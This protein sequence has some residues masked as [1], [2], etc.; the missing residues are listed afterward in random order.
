M[1][2]LP[3]SEEDYAYKS[4]IKDIYIE[5]PE[6]K[7]HHGSSE[8]NDDDEEDESVDDF[9]I[10]RE[11]ISK[12]F[13]KVLAD[14]N[15]T[16]AYLVT[17]YRGMGKTTF[18]KKVLNEYKKVQE[19][20]N[21]YLGP[22]KTK[23]VLQIDISFAQSDLKDIDILK[24]ITK[25]LLNHVEN[26]LLIKYIYKLFS[27]WTVTLYLFPIMFFF[28]YYLSLN[29][30]RGG[31]LSDFFGPGFTKISV[32]ADGTNLLGLIGLALFGSLFIYLIIIRL[33]L[34]KIPEFFLRFIAIRP[35]D[36]FLRRFRRKASSMRRVH[37][38]IFL[39]PVLLLVTIAFN[40]LLNSQSHTAPLFDFALKISFQTVIAFIIVFLIDQIITVQFDRLVEIY[41]R[42]SHLNDRCSTTMVN[43][44]GLQ[45][46][47]INLPIGFIEKKTRN[48]PIANAKEIEI[49]LT[50]IL[51]QLSSLK[52]RINRYQFVFVF[53]EL[54]KVESSNW[55]GVYHEDF[56]DFEKNS[57]ERIKANE[58]RDRKEVIM[59]ILASLKFFVNEA[60]AKFVFIA[61]R[62]MFEASL[63]DI[64]DRQSA[65][66]SIFHHIIYVDSFLKDKF[67]TKD[68]STL[69]SEMVEHYVLKTFYKREEYEENSLTLKEYYKYLIETGNDK[70]EKSYTDKKLIRKWNVVKKI[71]EIVKKIAELDKK[72]KTDKIEKL[73][74]SGI[75]RLEKEEKTL[76][77]KVNELHNKKKEELYKNEFE[78][79]K[80]IFTLQNFIVY[81]TYRSNGSPK[82]LLKLLESHFAVR[83]NEDIKAR[84]N[85]NIIIENL[86]STKQGNLFLHF[87]YQTQYKLGFITYLYRPFIFT[88]G[89]YLKTYSDSLLVST[90]FLMDHLIKYHKFAFSLHHLE[91]I[92]EIISTNKHTEMRF[93]IQ[94]LVNYLGNTHIRDTEIG[95][96]DYKFYNKTYLE[97]NYLSKT[98]EEE[99]AAFNFTLDENYGVKMY[100]RIKIKE[101]RSIYKDYKEKENF[102]HSIA[103]LNIQLGDAQ[104]F[105]TEYEDAITSYSDAIHALRFMKKN[106]LTFKQFIFLVNCKLKLGLLYEKMKF[107]DM[108]LGYYSD[109][110]EEFKNYFDTFFQKKEK[111]KVEI[112]DE[113][114]QGNDTSLAEADSEENFM[115]KKEYLLD[116][117]FDSIFQIINQAYLASLYVTEKFSIEGV[118]VNKIEKSLENFIKDIYTCNSRKKL[119]EVVENKT[120][121]IKTVQTKLEDQT[122]FEIQSHINPKN[123]IILANFYSNTGTLLFYKNYIKN[124]FDKEEKKTENKPDKTEQVIDTNTDKKEEIIENE[125]KKVEEAAT[126]A[127][128]TATVAEETATV[129]EQTAT[130]AEETATVV[131]Q[132]ATIAE[133]TAT[134]AEQ[135]ATVAEET[136]TIKEEEAKEDNRRFPELPADY[137][138]CALRELV[139][140][141]GAIINYNEKAIVDELSE[142]IRNY[143][144][145]H[146]KVYLKNVAHNL[147]KLADS[148]LVSVEVGEGNM[149][150]I[151]IN[152]IFTSKILNI[153]GDI[154]AHKIDNVFLNGECKE[155]TFRYIFKLY[156]L[157][158]KYYLKAGRNQ[159][160]SF[161]L[162]KILTLLNQYCD[163]TNEPKCEKYISIIE[164]T[165]FKEIMLIV[166][167]NGYSSDRNQIQKYKKAFEINVPYNP[168]GYSKYIYNH[169]SNNPETMEAILL[170][171]NLK[172]KTSTLDKD[173]IHESAENFILHPY[174]AISSQ[175]SHLL[176]LEFQTDFNKKLMESFGGLKDYLDVYQK[177]VHKHLYRPPHD[178]E[179]NENREIRQRGFD[180]I[181]N[182]TVR[183]ARLY[184]EICINSI[185]CLRE[186][187]SIVNIYG[188]NYMLNYTRLGY[189]HEKLGDWIVLLDLFKYSA[190]QKEFHWFTCYLNENS[191]LLQEAIK[192]TEE[193][194]KGIEQI[195]NNSSFNDTLNK[196]RELLE[197][198]NNKKTTLEQTQGE[199][200]SL[201]DHFNTN[202]ENFESKEEEKEID[203]INDAIRNADNELYFLFEAYKKQEETIDFKVLDGEES[204]K[205]LTNTFTTLSQKWA[206]I[207][208]KN[209]E[210][211]E[212]EIGTLIKILE[213]KRYNPVKTNQF[214]KEYKTLKKYNST[215]LKKLKL[216][217][218]RNELI[219][220]LSR[221]TFR[222]LI[223][224]TNFDTLDP[225]T[226]YQMALHLYQK[227]NLLHSEGGVYKEHFVDM[228]Y[229]E[230][231]FSDNLYHFHIALDRLE[232]N[233]GEIEKRIQ[234]L[235]SAISESLIYKYDYY[236]N[237]E[238]F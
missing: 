113:T 54:D 34:F 231:D 95:L 112:K 46:A 108:A 204:L 201:I 73:I 205:N 49:E 59:G 192:N 72:E 157:S 181:T 215:E 55:K 22:N 159:S 131:E 90:P 36:F 208:I 80:V 96:F 118:T 29:P 225:L 123:R 81:L 107:Y 216:T 195:T 84:L 155:H 28:I 7:F 99:A 161:Q 85:K 200:K 221:I 232:I 175:L 102:I 162:R 189:L 223:G 178:D 83:S 203:K 210:T 186:A 158:G 52:H 48:Y 233:S 21:S 11:E 145:K 74:K 220:N 58:F 188:I 132:T 140:A 226:E 151:K 224:P 219:Y 9:F 38:Y 213:S 117:S 199:L 137:Y 172:L 173:S 32:F 177:Q 45:S 10:G 127:K 160:Y 176:Q 69:L 53:D 120:L 198:F 94:D 43:E 20:R 235:N 91:L 15:E 89:Q 106:Q 25:S 133:Q 88:Y 184:M 18:V 44:S 77:N 57:Q 82:K 237:S 115:V 33:I 37:L 61:G 238:K 16:G 30:D 141:Q 41:Q 182:L 153:E 212:K 169:I 150:P 191:E 76:E 134:I 67:S 209:L 152:E 190:R 217:A 78:A 111:K 51:K 202:K 130:V 92:P 8:R 197:I 174:S 71:K 98:N 65:I 165:L 40:I 109:V 31:F 42:L 104:Y 50:N 124:T 12:Y 75:E 119:E 86:A 230:D 14:G 236:V 56:K 218:L 23:R 164:K 2:S 47:G 116:T 171:A 121:D 154:D 63:A 170:L 156:Y 103:F 179:S 193:I 105:D 222:D 1:S 138:K 168:K 64:S 6:Y 114:N 100:L 163:I 142:K 207:P 185:F 194:I 19:E 79:Q 24:L 148:L 136:T 147:S 39:T 139:L 27:D 101:M 135:T 126:V 229:L 87:S 129:A 234:K 144:N 166:S 227:T 68:K 122:N 149:K 13:T 146:D 17:G 66:G 4:F 187:I 167:L 35:I 5:L 128:E 211:E 110:I 183:E 206:T 60:K 125:T 143:E 93:F 26:R 228:H 180:I 70:I 214:N 196:L 3:F 97:L 62:E